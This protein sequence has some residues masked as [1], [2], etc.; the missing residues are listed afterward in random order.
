MKHRPIIFVALAAGTSLG[1]FSVPLQ[2]A[3]QPPQYIEKSYPI[4]SGNQLPDS[5]A[6]MKMHQKQALRK[7]FDAAN[8]ERKRQIDSDVAELVKL[9]R[10]LMAAVQ[11]PNQHRPQVEVIRK[12][13]LIEKLARDVRE[14]MRLSVNG[15]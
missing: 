8:T 10:E 13:E 9:A 1:S 12:A 5:N 3:N 7:N 14:K 15:S 11:E 6:Q 2:Q 4:P